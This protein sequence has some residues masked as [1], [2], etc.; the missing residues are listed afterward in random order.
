MEKIELCEAFYDANPEYRNAAICVELF[1]WRWFRVPV[2]RGEEAVLACVRPH[3]GMYVDG[4][5]G[6]VRH[7]MPQSGDLSDIGGVMLAEEE[8]I[9]SEK[10]TDWY[11]GCSYYEKGQVEATLNSGPRFHVDSDAN[12]L[13]LEKLI[14]NHVLPSVR[15]LPRGEWYCELE[16]MIQHADDTIH[17]HRSWGLGVTMYEAVT[18]ASY[19]YCET[20]KIIRGEKEAS[21][22]TGVSG[23]AVCDNASDTPDEQQ[24]VCEPGTGGQ[25]AL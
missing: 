14:E 15:Y 9:Q 6:W 4:Q 5:G 22:G 21:R 7:N 16:Y 19:S 18:R 1:G 8:G 12:R 23:E 25:G 24:H 13:L 3:G 2:C 20:R 17:T 11:G 10:F